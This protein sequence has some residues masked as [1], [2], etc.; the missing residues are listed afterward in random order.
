MAGPRTP[1][2]VDLV[3]DELR[4][5]ASSLINSCNIESGYIGGFATGNLYNMIQWITSQ[6]GDLDR[7]MPYYTSFPTI[8]VSIPHPEYFSPGDYDPLM[9]FIFAQAELGATRGLP[10]DSRLIP[11]LNK[12]EKRLK[13]EQKVMEP[14][15][16]RIPWWSDPNRPPR[17]EAPMAEGNA[18]EDAME[19]VPSAGVTLPGSGTGGSSGNEGT[20]TARKVRRRRLVAEEEGA[21]A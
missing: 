8:S 15:G 18:T 1:P 16:R 21:N 10:P 19:D 9:A 14:R 4:A 6:D 12:R 7:P 2:T 13:A 17:L 5:M 3:P 20:Q 11:I